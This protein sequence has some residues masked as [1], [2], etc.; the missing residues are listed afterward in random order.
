V[1]VGPDELAKNEAALKDLRGTG[2]QKTI[3]LDSVLDA[4]IG[5]LVGAS[6]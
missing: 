6:E 3:P 5:A 1:I 2:E 4:A